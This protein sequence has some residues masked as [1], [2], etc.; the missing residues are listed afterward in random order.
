V[1]NHF[2]IV[3]NRRTGAGLLALLLKS[4]SNQAT[5]SEEIEAG[6]GLGSVTPSAASNDRRKTSI[7]VLKRQEKDRNRKLDKWIYLD[8]NSDDL[9]GLSEYS[10]CGSVPR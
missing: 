5:A 10:G 8:N 9:I 6:P 2:G 1:G 4:K 7:C 3:L